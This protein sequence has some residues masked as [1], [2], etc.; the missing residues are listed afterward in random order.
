MGQ[1]DLGWTGRAGRKWFGM[2]CL[3]RR[4]AGVGRV[5]FLF[6]WS[7]R[8]H[9]RG[10]R[11][12]VSR[13]RIEPGLRPGPV[14]GDSSERASPKLDHVPGQYSKHPGRRK[15]W[16]SHTAPFQAL[17]GRDP[18]A[19]TCPSLSNLIIF[20]FRVLDMASALYYNQTIILTLA[21]EAVWVRQSV[22]LLSC[23]L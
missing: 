19:T 15:T 17:C 2:G 11:T 22:T 4:P 13:Q 16:L 20:R 1:Q 3:H 12:G 10:D 23:P 9:W 6:R 18:D 7:L 8:R 5:P 21:K 14:R